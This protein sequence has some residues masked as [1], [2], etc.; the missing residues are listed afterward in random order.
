MRDALNALDAALGREAV[1]A[2][3]IRFV[4]EFPAVSVYRRELDVKTWLEGATQGV[5]NRH[6]ALEELMMLWLTN[7][8]P[9][10]TPF[11]EL[12]DDAELRKQ[13][14]FL[15]MMAQLQKFFET[16]PRFGPENLTLIEE[17]RKPAIAVPYSLTGQL[18]FMVQRWGLCLANTCTACSVALTSSKKKKS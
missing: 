11:Q 7:I 4:D 10:T 5:P 6:L 13:T 18:E 12:F 8:N 14:A 2:T 15:Q 9:A 3:L 17:L 16:Q 1:D